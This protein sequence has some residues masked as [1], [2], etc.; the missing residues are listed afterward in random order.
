MNLH[1]DYLLNKIQGPADVKKLSLDQLHQVADEIR[2][3][4]IEKDAAVG[5]HLGP[6]LGIVEVTLAFHYVFDSPHDK[7]VWD[8]SH[9]SYPHKMLTGR[10]YGFL[11]PDRYNDVTPYSNQDESPHDFY[12]VGHTSTSVALAVGMAKARDLTGQSGDIVAVIGDGSLSGGMALEGLNNAGKYHGN[13]IIIFNDNQMSIDDVNGGMFDQLTTLRESN[14]EAPNNLFKAMGLDYRYIADGNDVETMINALK[15]VKGIDHPIV[16]HVN[17]LKGK[18][19]EP[20]IK[21]EETWHWHSPFKIEDGSDK[22]PATATENYDQIIKDELGNQIEAGKPLMVI[23]AAVPGV[24]GL[25]EMKE[26]YPNNYD[27]V[28]IAE[29]YSVTYATGLAENGARPVLFQNSTFFQ[30]AY[31]QVIHDMA[32]NHYPVVTIVKNGMISD[33]SST[34]QGDWDLAMLSNIPNIE[35][36]AP[37]NAEE[38]VSMLQWAL[39]QTDKP[40][41]IREP[42]GPVVH[43]AASTN[44]YSTIKAQVAQVGHQV[45]IVG[46]GDFFALGQKVVA[47]L[48]KNKITATLIN[49]VSASTLD[50]DTFLKVADNHDLIVTLEDASMSGGFGEHLDRLVAPTGTPVLNFGAEKEFTDVVPVTDLYERYHLTPAQIVADVKAKLAELNS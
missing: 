2:H 18:G 19:Y 12:R 10:A 22:A 49:P 50:K 45:A 25:D 28:D 32:L 17:T 8:I 37:T 38:L 34:H 13:L 4:V 26:K 47:E 29:Q 15:D 40:V 46:L 11:D 30:R 9:Q 3:L 36:L 14:G 33:Q 7:V 20:A 21:D 27:D 42:A 35:Y 48:A 31:D 39:K 16:L 24:F 1:P 6:N 5:G 44:D 43:G 23:T 41:I